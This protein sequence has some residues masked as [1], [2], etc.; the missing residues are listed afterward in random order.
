MDHTSGDGMMCKIALHWEKKQ[1]QRRCHLF[2]FDCLDF[3]RFALRIVAL[4]R[5]A[6]NISLTVVVP[7]VDPQSPSANKN[8]QK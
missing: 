8:V 1:Q 3:G 5:S 4:K 7:E 6:R 2:F